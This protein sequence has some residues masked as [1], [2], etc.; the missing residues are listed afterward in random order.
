[1]AEVSEITVA[2]SYLAYDADGEIMTTEGEPFN[3]EG[4]SRMK[5]GSKLWAQHFGA[6]LGD[7]LLEE[8]PEL[9]EDDEPVTAISI[10]RTVPSAAACMTTAAMAR[11]DDARVE[12]GLSATVPVH[13]WMERVLAVDYS[14]L[15][16]AGRQQYIQDTGYHL[17]AEDVKGSRTILVDDIRV[18]G[19][20]EILGKDLLRGKEHT[21]L[22][23]GYLAVMDPESAR[24][25]PAI[26]KRINTASV[27][28]L[29]DILDIAENDGMTVTLRA[30]K[31]V[32]E[33][34][35]KDVQQSFFHALPS[36]ILYDFYSGALSSG[37]EYISQYR[38]SFN[39]LKNVAIRRG[40]I[41]GAAM[42]VAR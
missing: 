27:T 38:Q 16:E 17:N 12:A 5:Y 20:A 28:T 8:V 1:M 15:D 6:L 10:Y 39:A 22:I 25:N 26:E 13:A 7:V 35:D 36:H 37:P 24:Q 14:T 18:T 30:M 4:Y 3:P 34:G 41:A 29:E 21:G 40:L 42:E 33:E 9:A 11:V 2:S 32:M 31:R 19:S 23:L